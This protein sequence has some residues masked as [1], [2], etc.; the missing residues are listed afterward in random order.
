MDIG[1]SVSVSVSVSVGVSVSAFGSGCGCVGNKV[2]CRTLNRPE[3]SSTTKP[4]APIRAAASTRALGLMDSRGLLPWDESKGAGSSSASLLP[5]R[6]PRAAR[7]DA[8]ATLGDVAAG[9]VLAGD[10]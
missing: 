10:P 2:S 8:Y 4:A 5:L 7:G 3:F 6:D 1:V 9:L